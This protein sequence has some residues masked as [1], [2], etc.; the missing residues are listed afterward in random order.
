MQLQAKQTQSSTALAGSKGSMFC[1]LVGG[2]HPEPFQDAFGAAKLLKLV[3]N[4]I[5]VSSQQ[6]KIPAV[7]LEN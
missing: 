1:K 4:D 3:L 7:I 5:F 2:D 6:E